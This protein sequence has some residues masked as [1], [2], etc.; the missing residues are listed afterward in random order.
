MFFFL[1]GIEPIITS[2]TAENTP[3]HRRGELFGYQGLVG[4]IGWMVSPMIGAYVS[5]NYE[6]KSILTV[7]PVFILI[8]S[9]I[10]Y[11][12]NKSKLN[13]IK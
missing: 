1:G 12:L 5:V 10:L 4:S 8:N 2:T 9:I 7:I 3:P 13:V 6:I 11:R